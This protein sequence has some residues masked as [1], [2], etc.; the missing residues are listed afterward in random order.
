MNK[1]RK[2]AGCIVLVVLIAGITCF[3]WHGGVL[4]PRRLR[5]NAPDSADPEFTHFFGFHSD[6]AIPRPVAKIE[7]SFK[8]STAIEVALYRVHDGKNNILMTFTARRSPN[9]IPRTLWRD[10]AIILALGDEQTNGVNL[11][12]LGCAGM[13]RATGGTPWGF[14]NDLNV[15]DSVLLTGPIKRK[16]EYT[17][18]AEGDQE[19]I[20]EQ[21]MSAEDFAGQNSGDYFL[22]TMY[23]H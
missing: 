7:G 1:K 2:R 3:V 20:A 23:V 11:I 17:V 19:I 15:V 13:S 10:M 21:H 4:F 22:V 6:A 16:H 8:L 14:T 5:V 9:V 12:S 18:Y